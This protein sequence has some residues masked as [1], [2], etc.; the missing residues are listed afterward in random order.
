MTVYELRPVEPAD[1]FSIIRLAHELLPERYTP[2]VFTQ[3]YESALVE[4]I[5][6][7]YFTKIVGFLVG[8]RIQKECAK[9]LMLAV[10]PSH[11]NNGVGSSLLECFFQRMKGYHIACVDLEVR[12]KNSQAV[13][14]YQKHQFQ[15]TDRIAQFYQNGEEASI[16]RR[17]L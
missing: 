10:V 5:V 11:Q 3:L 16:M 17:N 12:S 15:I 6:A 4:F 14:F 13:Q 2:V 8:S 7:V 1:L 9:L